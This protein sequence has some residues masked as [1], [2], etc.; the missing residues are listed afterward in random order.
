MEGLVERTLG[1]PRP[2]PLNPCVHPS[3]AELPFRSEKRGSYPLRRDCGAKGRERGRTSQEGQGPPRSPATPPGRGESH[4]N[5]G[6][7]RESRVP[8]CQPRLTAVTE[9]A[10]EGPRGL[11]LFRPTYAG[12]EVEGPVPVPLGGT[13]FPRQDTYQPSPHPLVTAPSPKHG[14]SRK[15]RMEWRG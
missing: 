5:Q 14:P 11:T 13:P 2:G 10:T 7:L 12:V 1:L 15:R 6:A 9:G 8:T 3:S 4:R